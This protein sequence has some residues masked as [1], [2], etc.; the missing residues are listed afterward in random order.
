MVTKFFK[1]NQNEL[2]Q[3]MF[4]YWLI[5]FADNEYVGKNECNKQL[6]K[7]SISLLEKFLDVENIDFISSLNIK[8]QEQ[9]SSENQKK[10]IFDIVISLKIGDD[11]KIIVI[12]D[13]TNSRIKNPLN[14][15]EKELI[16]KIKKEK[17][18]FY[19][20]SNFKK[21][22]L[23][24][25]LFRTCKMNDDEQLKNTN[26]KLFGYKFLNEFFY[27]FR[28]I[29]NYLFKDFISAKFGL[30]FE[31]INNEEWGHLEYESFLIDLKHKNDTWKK[32]G[33]QFE[34]SYDN[35]I[36]FRYKT[37]QAILLF[38]S[39]KCKSYKW[40]IIKGE[41]ILKKDDSFIFRKNSRSGAD[42]WDK[43]ANRKKLSSYEE[44]IEM[45]K[46]Y[47]ENIYSHF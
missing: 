21:D 45:I 43:K 16:N 36:I 15:Y 14:E 18:G 47:L 27:S 19:S 44:I 28:D 35:K 20:I 31:G 4:L 42:Y 41:E 8:L 7:C 1:N 40:N 9:L 6:K 12:E 2:V 38:E 11:K 3:D 23:K 37:L 33:F 29:D 26:F 10:Y 24:L 30:N 17:Y 32:S 39:K 46:W 22:D 25:I 5:S 34:S 13:K